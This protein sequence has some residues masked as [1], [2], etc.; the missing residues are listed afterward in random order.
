MLRLLTI[1]SV[2]ICTAG[3]PLRS[4]ELVARGRTESLAHRVFG[5]QPFPR[6]QAGHVFSVNG[7]HSS[8]R[9]DAV[10]SLGRSQVDHSITLPDAFQVSVAGMAVS[11][12]GDI[13][14]IVDAM[15]KDG[16]LISAIAWLDEHGSPFRVI[17]TS[18]FAATDIGFTADGSLWA[19]GIEKINRSQAHPSHHIIR[20]Y[21]SDGE[22][23]RSLLPR[24]A[25]A[26]GSWHPAHDSFLATSRN[27]I[28]FVSRGERTWTLLST[29]GVVVG[30]GDING[31]EQFEIASGAVTDS[32]RIFLSGE[33]GDDRTI[34][35]IEAGRSTQSRVDTSEV[36]AREGS[37][38]IVGSEGEDLVLLSM[39]DWSFIWTGTD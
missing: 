37:G 13:A 21:D 30:H 27:Y 12:D 33:W 36:F 34:S 35:I 14:V 9:V 26:G 25:F 18:P 3:L 7:S 1:L 24:S 6:Y 11:Y 28:A 39:R 10:S 16:R 23:V 32:G 31:S 2:A 15:D 19:A 38:H 20:Q 8:V 17:R 4:D 5:N 22:R 29:A